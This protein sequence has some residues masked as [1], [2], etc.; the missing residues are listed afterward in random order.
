MPGR[1]ASTNDKKVT[2]VAFRWLRR[3]TPAS[4]PLPAHTVPARLAGGSDSANT[5][6]TVPM[7]IACS[8]QSK[9][10]ATIWEHHFCGYH[11]EEGATCQ[12]TVFRELHRRPIF[13]T[14]Q[15]RQVPPHTTHSFFLQATQRRSC[16]ISHSGVL[17]G[18]HACTYRHATQS[19]CTAE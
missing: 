14:R 17:V 15:Q 1:A 10:A 6:T 8:H 18:V 19:P 3:S 9:C 5:A 11:F 12:H 4:A 7:L 13:K 2:G 16:S